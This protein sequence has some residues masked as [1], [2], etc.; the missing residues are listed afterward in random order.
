MPFRKAE[1]S[2]FKIRLA[3]CGPTGSGKTKSALRIA[4]AI[5][6]PI[7]VIDSERK[8]SLRYADEFDFAVDAFEED[9]D[10]APL[11]FVRKIQEGENLFNVLIVDGI[12]PA[13]AGKGGALE[14]VDQAVIRGKGN[15]FTAWRDVTPQH[16]ALVDAMLACK[17][18]LIVTMRMKMEYVMEDG[19]RG[20]KNI[21]KV[22]LGIIQRDGIE[23]EFDVVGEMDQEHHLFFTKTRCSALDGKI[24]HLPGPEVAAILCEWA[25]VTPGVVNPGVSP[26]PSEADAPEDF[27]TLQESPPLSSPPEDSELTVQYLINRIPEGLTKLGVPKDGLAEAVEAASLVIMRKWDVPNIEQIPD[28]AAQ[29]LRTFMCGEMIDRLHDF[30]PEAA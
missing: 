20:K 1:K 3:I 2:G 12:S 7:G 24:F 15:K 9:S 30:I 4:Q 23:Y 21:K 14:L 29:E 8:S 10:F 22:G 5:G 18:H 11:T 6:G 16:N 13:W 28:S 17:C 19:D 26:L 27:P 25:G